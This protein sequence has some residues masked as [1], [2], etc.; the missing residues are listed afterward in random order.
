[1]SQSPSSTAARRAIT[2]KIIHK[3]EREIILLQTQILSYSD[4]AR[5]LTT[6]LRDKR[7][8][9]RGEAMMAKRLEQYGFSK[10]TDMLRPPPDRSNEAKIV[11]RLD[12]DLRISAD[13]RGW[14][15][16]YAPDLSLTDS[17]S[18]SSSGYLLRTD[19]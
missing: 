6:D 4:Q 14:F 10:Q 5:K 16:K 18:P 7:L 13:L 12:R 15:N 9:R 3:K 8:K 2:E 1:M 19:L 17:W 11:T